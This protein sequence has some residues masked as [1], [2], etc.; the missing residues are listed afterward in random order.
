M[1][2]IIHGLRV[3]DCKVLSRIFGNMRKA[4]CGN[5]EN[6]VMKNL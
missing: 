3:L 2:Q 4:V 5:G 1:L 6:C